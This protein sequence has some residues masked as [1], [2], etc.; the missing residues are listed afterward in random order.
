MT[1]NA[2]SGSTMRNFFKALNAKKLLIIVLAFSI[3][4]IIMALVI[5]PLQGGLISTNDLIFYSNKTPEQYQMNYLPIQEITGSYGRSIFIAFAMLTHVL[6]ANLNLGGAWYAVTSESLNIRT[7]QARFKRL[8]RS[9]TL[10]NVIVF[11]SGATLAAGAL[12]LFFAFVP[13]LSALLFHIYFWPLFIEALLFFG[14]VFFLY[15]YWFSWDKI[16]NRSHQ[17]LGYGYGIDVFLQ[18]LMINMVAAGMLTP[19]ASL[20]FANVNYL[21]MSWDT[22][23][24]WWFN[25][26]TWGLTIHRFVAAFSVFGFILAMLAMFHH[27]AREDEASKKYWDWV[28]YQG[29]TF[30]LVGLLLQPLFGVIYINNIYYYNNPAFQM[31]MHSGRAWEMLLMVTLFSA[32]FLVVFVY[33][34]DR[35]R[36]LLNKKE[37]SRYKNMFNAFLLISVIATFFLVQPSW[38]GGEY[39]Y[40]DTS[41][42]NPLGLMLYKYFAMIALSAIAAAILGIDSRNFRKMEE[43]EWGKL[44]L[45]SR[46]AGVLAGIIGIF[47]VVVM[48]YTRESAR[49]PYVIYEILPFPMGESHPTPIA[50]GRIFLVWGI[51]LALIL[52]VFWF[53]SRTT[54]HQPKELEKLYE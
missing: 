12:V 17:I 32:L 31:I 37:N 21:T 5:V 19:G 36:D 41:L 42:I 50:V 40:S 18:V 22:L 46:F 16:S 20:N 27:K 9:I 43:E 49:S 14:E 52:L 39:T 25:P 2:I 47:L 28:G 33:Y 24:S 54:A 34:M 10:F 23:W 44:S 11:S 35:R 6:I 1:L 30:G 29:I 51:I 8:A 26:S 53:V 7:G 45:T 4:I 15:T 38:I 48:G 13:E 3:Y